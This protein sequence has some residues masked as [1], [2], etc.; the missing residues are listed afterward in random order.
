MISKQSPLLRDYLVDTAL[1]ETI[2]TAKLLYVIPFEFT[3]NADI[4]QGHFETLAAWDIH[5]ALAK[6]ATNQSGQVFC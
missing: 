3:P 6:V 5:T 1:A 4:P 2:M